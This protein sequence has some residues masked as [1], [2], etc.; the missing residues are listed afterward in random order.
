MI[1][2]FTLR[3]SLF[4]GGWSK[5]LTREVVTMPHVVSVLLFDP[6]KD[7]VLL[8][9]QFRPPVF[10]SEKP[11]WILE[12][13]AGRVDQGESLEQAAYR[14]V[15]E[16]TG[17]SISKLLFIA[18]YYP[19]PGTSNEKVTLYC[20][21]FSGDNKADHRHFGVA[22][23]GEDIKTHVLPAT[24]LFSLVGENKINNA[25]SLIALQWLRMHRQDLIEKA[26]RS[27]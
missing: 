11:G 21:L 26:K 8:V 14:E 10:F 19:T 3:Y 15:R 24:Y 12:I 5:V 16:E 1:K 25:S 6:E 20:G 4:Q 22:D 17:C 27:K 13:V 7:V 2:Q 9:E 23:E 18:D